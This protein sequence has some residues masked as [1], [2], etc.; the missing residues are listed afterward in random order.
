MVFDDSE[1]MKFADPYTD[2][3]KA[4][5]LAAT[6]FKIPGPRGSIAS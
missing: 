5:S 6:A 2:N 4:S 3:A 1:S